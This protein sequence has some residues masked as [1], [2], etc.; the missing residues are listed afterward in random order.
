MDVHNLPAVVRYKI[1]ER[2]ICTPAPVKGLSMHY[3]LGTMSLA[4]TTFLLSLI[5]AALPLSCCKSLAA[6][7]QTTNDRTAKSELPSHQATIDLLQL[8]MDCNLQ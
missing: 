3:R 7:A 5:S 8:G 6:K 1:H 2:V 4:A